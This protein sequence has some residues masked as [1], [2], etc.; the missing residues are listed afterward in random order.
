ML[1]GPRGLGRGFS[2]LHRVSAAVERLVA[3]I[4]RIAPPVVEEVPVW[5][6]VG[7]LAAEDYIATLDLPMVPKSVLDG[8]AVRSVDIEG[9]SQANPAM[10][11]I[12]GVLTPSSGDIPGINPGEAYRVYTGAPLPLGADLVVPV[13]A[14]REERGWVYIFKPY[15]PGYG[16]MSPGEDYR[17]G[18]P[19]ARRGSRLT[20]GHVGVLAALGF[21]RVRV[22]RLPRIALFTVGDE[23]I[24]P[25]EGELRGG[26]VY[27]ST[28]PL[29]R[30]YLESRGF[31]VIDV[32]HVGDDPR[33]IREAYEKGM[34]KAPITAA[35]GGSSVGDRD[36]TAEVLADITRENGGWYMHGFLLRPGRPAAVGSTGSR[37][38]FS[39]SGFPVAAWAQVYTIL[40][41]SVYRAYGIPW[42][43]DPLVYGVASR[44][45]VSAAG[46]LDVIRVRV[47][48][49]NAT[50]YVE[51]L[52]VTGSGILS[53]LVRGNAV[54]LAEPEVTGFDEGSLVPVRLLNPAIPACKG[55]GDVRP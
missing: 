3:E 39:L 42:P 2:R 14:V 11:R 23:V 21:A 25:G 50:L 32:G 52:R 24:E 20:W 27:D 13:E 15:P 8:Y 44:R 55:E 16:V 41:Q 29:L 6:A 30:A 54:I 53:T 1:V 33:E 48:I 17:R 9:A 40:E 47:C 45:V 35:I 43:S 46:V 49:D 51:P 38:L 26:L 36:Y 37:I 31:E 18:E 28:K 5:N 10:L 34:E 19:V 22:Y 4:R 7:R 12:A